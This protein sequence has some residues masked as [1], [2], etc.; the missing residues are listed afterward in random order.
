MNLPSLRERRED[1][2]VLLAALL[3]KSSSGEAGPFAAGLSLKADA[4]RLLCTY[5]WPLNVRELAQCLTRASALAGGAP[6]GK[7]HLPP[8]VAGAVHRPI[9]RFWED[10]TLLRKE[11]LTKLEEHGG[12][13]ADVARALG[14]ARMQVHR[15]MTRLGIDPNDFRK[16]KST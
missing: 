14:R 4:G 10:D 5:E 15:W 1:L 12:N 13:V 7:N 2:G 9:V 16:G 8:Q 3:G 11:L 6:I